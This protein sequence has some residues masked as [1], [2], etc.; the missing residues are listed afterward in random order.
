MRPT[1]MICFVRT[2]LFPELPAWHTTFELR[3]R[4]SGILLSDQLAIHILE[5]PKFTRPI[6]EVRKPLERWM[7]FLCHGADLDPDKLPAELEDPAIRHALGEMQMMTQSELE[8]ERYEARLKWQRDYAA[9]MDDAR[10]AAAAAEAIAEARGEARGE[11]RAKEIVVR[12]VHTYQRL[13][14][15]PL[16]PLG[17]LQQRSLPELEILIHGLGEQLAASFPGSRQDAK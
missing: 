6:Q 12:Q 11:A 2:R 5:L 4:Q 17:E 7:Y 1:I 13:L 16:S 15:Q 9:A 14:G 3:E 8:R 10:R